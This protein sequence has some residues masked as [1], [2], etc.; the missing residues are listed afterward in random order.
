MKRLKY[1]GESV[2][3]IIRRERDGERVN[4]DYRLY[5]F[6]T[7]YQHLVPCI[8]SCFDY[9]IGQIIVVLENGKEYLYD[10]STSCLIRIKT[11]VDILELTE[12]E[13][14]KGF[15]FRLRNALYQSGMHLYEI[16]DR[17]DI[18]E[19]CISRYVRG[20]VVPSLYSI[21]RLAAAIDCSVDELLPRDFVPLDD[22]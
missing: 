13:W 12:E 11:F 1:D 4:L 3:D 14:I 16:A 9:D 2:D 6:I 8:D 17:V 19:G 22:Y 21:S 20:K 7:K 5:S 10:E 15:A 18:A